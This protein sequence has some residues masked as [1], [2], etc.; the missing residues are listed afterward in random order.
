MFTVVLF[1]ALLQAAP[2]NSSAGLQQAQQ[3]LAAGKAEA[4]LAAFDEAARTEPDRADIQLGR[5]RALAALRKFDE[6]LQ[7]CDRSLQAQP[8]N[9]EALRDRGHYKLNMGRTDDAESDLQKAEALNSADRNIYYHLGLAHY[10]KGE[11]GEA[12]R[13]FQG[14][15]KNSKEKA[16]QIECDAWLYPSLVR[17][18]QKRDA[19]ALLDGITP[20]PS[21]TGHPA[22]YFD[23]LLLFKGAKTEDQVSANLNAEGALSLESIGYSLALWHLLNGRNDK[24]REYYARVLHEDLPFAWGYRAAQADVQRLKGSGQ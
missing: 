23:R 21:I 18:G 8:N 3:L 9:P 4:A 17:A 1:L 5:C 24:A 13:Q 7:A 15:L 16:D 10:F 11:F 22:W 19:Q 20:D 2:R 12:A 14:C 6:A